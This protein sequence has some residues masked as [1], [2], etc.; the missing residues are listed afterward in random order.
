MGPQLQALVSKLSIL[1]LA[2]LL[3]LSKQLHLKQNIKREQNSQLNPSCSC[4]GPRD[5]SHLLSPQDKCLLQ[6]QNAKRKKS[7]QPFSFSTTFYYKQPNRQNLNQFS[8][9]HSPPRQRQPKV[10]KRKKNKLF[11]AR[12]SLQRKPQI[13]SFVPFFD[14]FL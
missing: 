13:T 6:R 3:A 4:V 10:P 11:L 8:I 1:R 5:S 7:F 12:K 9:H 14:L 2:F